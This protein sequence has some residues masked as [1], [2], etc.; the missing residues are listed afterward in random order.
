MGRRVRSV[1]LHPELLRFRRTICNLC[2][3][4]QPQLWH[5]PELPEPMLNSK[6]QHAPW[7]DHHDPVAGAQTG[8]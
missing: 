4:A 5:S 8:R 7:N 1:M 6:H 2:E 3:F